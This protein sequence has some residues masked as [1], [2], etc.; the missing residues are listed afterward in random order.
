MGYL[1]RFANVIRHA[2]INIAGRYEPTI[3]GLQIFKFNLNL[4]N[5]YLEGSIPSKL[6]TAPRIRFSPDGSGK[7]GYSLA[8]KMGTVSYTLRIMEDRYSYWQRGDFVTVFGMSKSLSG[9]D[10]M[11]YGE[12]KKI[13]PEGDEDRDIIDTFM[14]NLTRIHR[15]AMKELWL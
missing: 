14:D 10:Y 7:K 9:G 12:G 6:F 11:F 8:Y 5:R 1:N 4:H 15:E 3:N 2:N 13:E